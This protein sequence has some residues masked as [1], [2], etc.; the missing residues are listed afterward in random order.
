M[1]DAGSLDF[2]ATVD[3]YEREAEAL[4]AALRAGDE[5][6]GWRFKW[7]HPRFKGK[8][9]VDVDAARAELDLADARTVIAQMYSFDTWDD[10]VAFAN[11]VAGD[12]PVTRFETAVDAVVS[13]DVATLQAMLRDD[14]S[15]VH[16][17]S[18]RRHHCTLLHYLGANGV[19]GVRQKTP[20]N[21]VDVAKLLLDSG[22]EPDALADLYNHRCS[23]MSMLV[24]S[25]HPAKAG[26][27]VALAE[28]LLDYGA[29]LAGPGTSWSSA[30]L[31]AL[32][33]GYLDTAEALARREGAVSD[34][35]TAAGL[36]RVDDTARLLPG[37]DAARLQ[38]ALALAAQLGHAEVVRLLL[39]AGADPGQFCPEGFHSH[40]TPLHNAVWNDQDDVVRL[41]VD[42]GAPLDVQDKIYLGT[43]LDWAIYGDKTAAAEFLRQHG[44]VATYE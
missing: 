42:A 24:S 39:E 30:T 3:D 41:L 20:P 38:L 17:R 29:Q 12:G 13:G 25:V 15:L 34:L 9:I 22:A 14:P 16:A 1:S 37:A 4:F 11:E 40:A 21:A 2:R 35:P 18:T 28:T 43:P 33:F 44:A 19:E 27:Q 31:T 32:T 26:L 36:G 10:L 8:T 5:G 6:A 23:T 7:E